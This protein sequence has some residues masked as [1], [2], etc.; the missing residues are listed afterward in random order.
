MAR[1]KLSPRGTGLRNGNAGARRG[2][3]RRTDVQRRLRHAK[4]NK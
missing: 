2:G 1:T 4:L 3:K